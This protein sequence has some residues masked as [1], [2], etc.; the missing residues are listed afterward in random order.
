MNPV[1]FEQLISY[2]PEGQDICIRD[3]VFDYFCKTLEVGTVLEDHDA[4]DAATKKFF[5]QIFIKF[6][7]V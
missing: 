5:D 7:S 1:Q 2:R 3:A 6:V 4:A